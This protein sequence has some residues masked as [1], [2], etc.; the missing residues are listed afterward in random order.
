MPPPRTLVVRPA[1]LSLACA[2]DGTGLQ[3]MHWTTWAPQ[4]SSGYGTEWENDCTPNCA[5]GQIHYY[6]ALAVLWG[7]A[8]KGHP[9]EERYT[10]VTLVYPG[11]RPPVYEVVTQTLALAP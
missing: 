6:P 2:D 3:G 5:E 10:E 1:T 4:L 7:S 11:A 8:V 9:G